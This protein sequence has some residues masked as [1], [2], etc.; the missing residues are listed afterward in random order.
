MVQQGCLSACFIY[1]DRQRITSFGDFF[2]ISTWICVKE[3]K[4]RRHAS[5]QILTNPFTPLLK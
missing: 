1:M 2:L 3:E 4:E 5:L